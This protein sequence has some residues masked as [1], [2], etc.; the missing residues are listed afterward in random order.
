MPH[1]NAEKRKI[2]LE[3]VKEIFNYNCIATEHTA[4]LRQDPNC[5]A[6]AYEKCSVNAPPVNFL[7]L[8]NELES[9][10]SAAEEAALRECVT[11]EELSIS[12][13]LLGKMH[14]DYPYAPNTKR[15]LEL[16]VN[17]HRHPLLAEAFESAETSVPPP[18]DEPPCLMPSS[19]FDSSKIKGLIRPNVT[20]GNIK[21]YKRNAELLTDLVFIVPKESGDEEDIFRVSFTMARKKLKFYYVVFC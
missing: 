14:T 8:P 20:A 21:A 6:A 7:P 2:A 19:A 12:N 16:P 15:G 17:P 4:V 5:L 3:Q 11:F 10:I 13:R 18:T 1:L 9:Y